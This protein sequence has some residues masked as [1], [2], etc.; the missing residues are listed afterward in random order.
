M[1]SKVE[2]LLKLIKENPHLK[3]IPMVYYDCVSEDHSYWSASWGEASVD[4]YYENDGRIYFKNDDF[5]ELVDKFYNDGYG[6][7]EGDISEEE[8]ERLANEVNWAKCIVVYIEP[9]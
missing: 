5:E 3:I 8:A 7:Y 1:N 2:N 6:S 9:V 4:E